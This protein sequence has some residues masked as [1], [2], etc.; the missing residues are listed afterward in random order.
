[1]LSRRTGLTMAL[2]VLAA[3]LITL[4]AL[5]ARA[6]A[7]NAGAGGSICTANADDMFMCLPAGRWGGVIGSVTQRTDPASGLIGSVANVFAQQS[8]NMQLTLPNLILSMT[9]TLWGIA[10]SLTQF[11]ATFPPLKK[12]GALIDQASGSLVR[13]VMASNIP[14]ILILIGLFA[15]IGALAFQVGRTRS[16]VKRLLVSV[17]CLAVAGT[18]GAC[19]A[20][21]TD[22]SPATGSPWWVVSQLN[23]TV[24]T[25]QIG[26]DLPVPDSGTGLM[27][28]WSAA[29]QERSCRDYLAAMDEAY[30]NTEGSS[31]YTAAINQMWEET[32]LRPWVTMQYGSPS[33]T[34]SANKHVASNANMAYCHVLDMAANIDPDV[35]KDTTNKAMN[36]R[37]DSKTAQWIFTENGWM[38]VQSAT[39]QAKGKGVNNEDSILEQDSITKQSRAALFWETCTSDGTGES[40]VKAR[41][42]WDVLINNM[43][44][45]GSGEIKNGKTVVRPKRDGAE[46]ESVGGTPDQDSSG[47]DATKGIMRTD[48]AN[49]SAATMKVCS[50]ILT[51][52]AFHTGTGMGFAH[53]DDDNATHVNDDVGHAALM[54]YRFDLPNNSDSWREANLT[55]ANDPSSAQNGVRTT[56]DY[57]YGNK[58]PDTIAGFGSMIGAIANVGVWGLFAIILIV[59]KFSLV[60]MSLFLIVSLFFQAVPVGAGSARALVRWGKSCFNV[61]LIGILYGFLGQIVLFTCRMVAS[62]ANGVTAGP[63][64][65]LIVGM[66]PILA[67]ALIGLLSSAILHKG[68]PFNIKGMM[69]LATGGEMGGA[70]GA[71]LANPRGMANSVRGMA[72]GMRSRFKRGEH[73]S[74]GERLSSKTVGKH[75]GGPSKGEE[76][77]NQAVDAQES[78]GRQLTGHDKMSRHADHAKDHA[79]T[80]ALNVLEAHDKNNSVGNRLSSLAKDGYH[81]L[82]SG[83]SLA[84]ASPGALKAA[85]KNKNLRN[86]VATAGALAS[87]ATPFGLVGAA[88]LGKKAIDSARWMADSDNRAKLVDRLHTVGG[89]ASKAAGNAMQGAGAA[90]DATGAHVVRSAASAARAVGAAWGRT[91]TAQSLGQWGSRTATAW[92]Q[93]ANGIKRN[94]MA[95]QRARQINYEHGVGAKARIEQAARRVGQSAGAMASGAYNWAYDKGQNLH[96]TVRDTK[97]MRSINYYGRKAGQSL[98]DLPAALDHAIAHPTQF[99]NARVGMPDAGD[100]PMT[101]LFSERMAQHAQRGAQDSERRTARLDRRFAGTNEN[102]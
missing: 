58:M 54:S 22:D 80:A 47:D 26:L 51:N 9:Q 68:N 30:E 14:A 17:L 35:Q 37:I 83:V 4:V 96:D 6:Y 56:V 50:T 64:Y 79:E 53:P 85:A 78:K 98:A 65:N 82:R 31:D 57:L 75:T 87:F 100:M 2:M 21:S 19:A 52:K 76:L 90:W 89:V 25:M 36:L 69:R 48:P 59:S 8:R 23:N 97:L 62:L 13:S 71:M 67:M 61:A 66:S 28:G 27:S 94:V 44:D 7:D 16:T 49:A 73:G 101:L 95:R 33:E 77:L 5:P 11:A 43:S 92:K 24:N 18:M 102:E 88:L 39:A 93:T 40:G 38:G 3:F 74:E 10:L 42:G 72:R 45:N 15:L 55:L 70:M 41:E 60:F 63:F 81:G 86:V 32:A 20:R 1:M 46:L 34:T 29:G 12:F 99:N 91:E 84:A